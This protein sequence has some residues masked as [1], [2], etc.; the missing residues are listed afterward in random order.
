MFHRAKIFSPCLIFFDQVDPLITKRA[1]E[2]DWVLE[3]L[4]NQVN[5]AALA[6]KNERKFVLDLSTIHRRHFDVAFQRISPSVSQKMN[7]ASTWRPLSSV[8]FHFYSCEYE[9][10]I[11]F[12]EIHLR[13]FI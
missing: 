10:C 4:L 13:F 6:A 7:S 1:K 9:V 12:Q 3:R 8:F 11:V 2:G 5:E